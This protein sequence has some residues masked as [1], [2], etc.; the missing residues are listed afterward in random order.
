[1]RVLGTPA[2]ARLRIAGTAG[3]VALHRPRAPP[4]LLDGADGIFH[5]VPSG[6]PGSET[7]P[8][9]TMRRPGARNRLADDLNGS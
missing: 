7:A 8:R 6:H 3:H 1:M 5:H 2:A 9:V 4:A